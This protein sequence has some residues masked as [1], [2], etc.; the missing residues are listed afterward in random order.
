MD[1]ADRLRDLMSGGESRARVLAITSGKG[2]VGKTNVAVNLAI[3]LVEMGKRVIVVDVDIGLANADVLLAVQPRLHLGHVLSG[4]VSPLDALTLTPSGVSL[5]AGSSGVRQM[6][7]L[8]ASEREFLIRGFQELEAYADFIFIDTG[9]GI[10]SNVVQFSS[11]ADEVLVVTVPEPTAITD[12][13]AVVK[14]V[15]R[16]KGYGRM[17]LVVNM[18]SSSGEAARVGG[19]IQS[20]ARRFLGIETDCLGHVVLDEQVRLAVRRKRAVLLDAPRSPAAACFRRL[21]ERLVGEEPNARAR[22]FFKRFASAIH[23]VMS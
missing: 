11:A 18:C 14:A 19:R 22:G 10:S 3:A 9:S 21:A 16:E 15:S 13:Y 6:S 12:A 5:L 8:E 20:V 4:E 7:D 23:G 2:G 17:R 1:Q